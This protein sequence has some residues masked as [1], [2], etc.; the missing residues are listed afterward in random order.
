VLNLAE[1]P[2]N[3]PP[4]RRHRFTI[5]HEIDRWICHGLEGRAP[6]LEPSHCRASDIANDVDRAVEREANIFATELLM[7]AAAVRAAWAELVAQSHKVT[8]AAAMAARLD[9]SPSAMGWRLFNPG[10]VDEKPA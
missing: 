7:P 8:P 3:D 5:A 2:R 4:L 6:V 1:S 10:L 9:A